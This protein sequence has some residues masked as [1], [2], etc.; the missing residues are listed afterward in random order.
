MPD[1]SFLVTVHSKVYPLFNPWP[2]R[3]GASPPVHRLGSAQRVSA[4]LRRALCLLHNSL[5][6]S[7]EGWVPA[8]RLRGGGV[9]LSFPSQMLLKR[10]VCTQCRKGPG[11]AHD[12]SIYRGLQSIPFHSEKGHAF[13]FHLPTPRQGP[14]LSLSALLPSTL[15]NRISKAVL[16]Q[17]SSRQSLTSREWHR[18][19][20]TE[21]RRFRKAVCLA[22]HF[23][24]MVWSSWES[25]EPRHFSE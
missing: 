5:S 2:I 4:C 24:A 6:E 19:C 9:L 1:F 23:N 11:K 21:L 22:Y 20:G 16:G 25:D 17:W 7:R 15:A 8:P 14:I 18:Q 3:L 12:V 13:L 10:V